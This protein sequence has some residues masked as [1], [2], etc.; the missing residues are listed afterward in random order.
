MF[1]SLLIRF[2][3]SRLPIV[4]RELLF[5]GQPVIDILAISTPARLVEFVSKRATSSRV[6]RARPPVYLVTIRSP[7]SVTAISESVMAASFR[8]IPMVRLREGENTAGHSTGVRIG[9]P[10]S[11]TRN[12]RNL[13]GAFWLAFRPTMCTSSGPS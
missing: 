6:G 1:L 8:S 12:T 13:A 11:F 2:N 3:W 10:L 4:T 7:V 5:G 9:A